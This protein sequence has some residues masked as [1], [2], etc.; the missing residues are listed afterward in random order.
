MNLPDAV[1]SKIREICDKFQVDEETVTKEYVELYTSDFVQTDPQFKDDDDKHGFCIRAIWVKYASAQPTTEYEFI[2]IGVKSP[3]KSK[4][5]GL[6]RGQIYALVKRSKEL[7]KAVIFATGR[8]SFIV[9]EIKPFFAYKARLASWSE[10]RLSTTSIT[11]LSEPKMITV[12][13]LDLLKKYLNVKEIKVADTPYAVSSMKDEKFVDEWDLRL[14]RGI[15]LNFGE[16]GDDESGKWAYYIIA[17]ESATGEERVTE[18]G[19]IIPN[20]LWVW[21]PPQFLKYDVG[22]ELYF[23]GTIALSDREP[24]MNAISVIPVHAKLLMRG[25]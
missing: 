14:I 4:F 15:V 24:R 5:D 19:I 21:I 1:V 16:G 11:K 25:D 18:N 17:D 12:N 2:P 10:D 9:N 13:P 7:T 20:R 3:K 8:E 6:W 23:L 22:S